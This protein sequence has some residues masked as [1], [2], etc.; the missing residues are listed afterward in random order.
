MMHSDSSRLGPTAFDLRVL[1]SEAPRAAA[2]G[3]WSIALTQKSA[4]WIESVTTR[5][6]RGGAL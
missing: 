4:W 3:L 1:N 2:S 5:A 6:L